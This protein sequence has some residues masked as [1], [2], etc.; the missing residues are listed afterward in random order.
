MNVLTK[1]VFVV[2]IFWSYANEYD[3]NKINYIELTTLSELTSKF[4]NFNGDKANTNILIG[5]AKDECLDKLKAP[6]FRGIQRNA[7]G[8][9]VFSVSLPLK[10]FP[11]EL[12]GDNCAG[13]FWYRQNTLLSQ[14]TTHTYYFDNITLTQW[15][16]ELMRVSLVI[17]SNFDYP[18]SFWY[19]PEGKDEVS[20]GVLRPNEEFSIKTFLGHIFLARKVTDVNEPSVTDSIVDYFVVHE[21]KYVLSSHNRI[22]TCDSNELTSNQYNYH[23]TQLTKFADG[24]IDCNDLES[25][26][27]EF[28]H[29]VWYIK[30][31]G[32]NYFQPKIVPPVTKTGFE[33]R[34]LPVETHKW[35][36]EW[37]IT[38]QSTS[39]VI[40]R[41][42]GPVLNQYAAETGKFLVYCIL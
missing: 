22:E 24:E 14:P 40:E 41:K 26:F 5:V 12:D 3:Y 20:Q 19:K 25:R 6:A 30:R 28:T 9:V 1:F 39:E 31:L 42:V 35:L 29:R 15:G 32:L 17:V 36:K 23:G 10:E 11:L 34:Q 4:F 13:L 2:N 38:T 37:Y 27:I 18:V 7:G 8:N 33:L 16:K 21:D